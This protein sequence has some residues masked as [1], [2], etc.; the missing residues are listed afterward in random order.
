MVYAIDVSLSLSLSRNDVGRL[1]NQVTSTKI[2][3][4]YAK[5]CEADKKYMEATKAYEAAREFDN[6]IR[7]HFNS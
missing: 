3:G 4:Q 5:A 6:A 7:Y 1:L 2:H